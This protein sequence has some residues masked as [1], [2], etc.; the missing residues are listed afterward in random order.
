MRL[1]WFILKGEKKARIVFTYTKVNDNYI[2]VYEQK[3][4]KSEYNNTDW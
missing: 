4:H 1:L 2:I 3:H